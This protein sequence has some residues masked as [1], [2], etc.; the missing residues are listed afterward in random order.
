MGDTIEIFISY[1]HEDIKLLDTV[2]KALDARL[3]F[4]EKK[5][6][7]SIWHDRNLIPGSVAAYEINRHMQ[8]ARIILLLISADF[9]A[10]DYCYSNE[11]LDLM[12]RNKMGNAH[13]IPVI[14]RP[15]YW[16]EA[17]FGELEPLP[18]KGKPLI[19]WNDRDSAL[20]SI[21]EGVRKVVDELIAQSQTNTSE[22]DGEKTMASSTFSDGYALLIGVGADLPVTVKDA[23]ALHDVLINP[24]RAAYPTVNVELLIE[25]DANRQNILDAFERLIQRVDNNPNA[26][27]I[28]YFSGHGGK[29]FRSGELAEY[30]LVPYN[31]NPTQRANT[32]ISGKEFTEKVEA[33]KAR[34]LVVL[35]DCCHAGGISALK[36]VSETFEKA[37]LPPDL[38]SA[39]ERGSGRVVIASSKENEV[40]YTGTPY[41][42]FTACLVEALAG[43][44]VIKKDGFAR[45]L[46]ILSYLFGQVPLRTSDRQ[47][48]FVNKVLNL[49]DNFPLC[50]YAGGAKDILDAS[51]FS[52]NPSTSVSITAG[53][54]RRLEEKR[55]EL[56]SSWDIR[57]KR[58]QSIRATLDIE[59]DPSLIFK[60]QQQFRQESAIL[61]QVEN[62]LD[63][64]D[65][66]LQE[67]ETGI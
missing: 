12:K 24:V 11:M 53:K 55:G 66:K 4:L 25:A 54:R 33:I 57:S 21:A 61:A 45:I 28:V 39:L 20:F 60:Y 42:V 29:I 27:V 65:Q 8:S 19:S 36:D 46:D 17:P 47:H 16:Q 6:L 3:K 43:K 62:E 30:F 51:L 18:E 26:T 49:D 64:L 59:T 41:S 56:Q 38:L 67:F 48:P 14:L 32:A 1:A 40:S 44:A 50:Y 13:V 7:V 10:S 52:P 22:A 63:I 5:G 34:K 2:L 23:T 9:M 15:T 58:A 31:Y 35:L 37:P